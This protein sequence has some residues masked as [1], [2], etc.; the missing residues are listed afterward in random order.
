MNRAGFLSLTL[1]LLIFIYS[2]V[3]NLVDA[4]HSFLLYWTSLQQTLAY[5][6]IIMLGL[7][8]FPNDLLTNLL[9]E[10]N[11]WQKNYKITGLMAAFLHIFFVILLHYFQHTAF[12]Q[13]LFFDDFTGI[14]HVLFLVILFIL[15]LILSLRDT[16]FE[17]S[18]AYFFLWPLII[19]HI[20]ISHADAWW[21]PSEWPYFLPPIS[22]FMFIDAISIFLV[23]LLIISVKSTK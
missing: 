9:G 1:F 23:I 7:F 19:I 17:K 13:L 5:L 6:S 8:A 12:S 3:R 15:L 21:P 16:P 20:Y 2:F 22:A 14:R 11:S 4:E 10:R 18:I